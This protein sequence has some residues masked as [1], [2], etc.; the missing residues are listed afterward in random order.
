MTGG[1]ILPV[2]QNAIDHIIDIIV[3]VVK[4]QR[5]PLVAVATLAVGYMIAELVIFNVEL[6]TFENFFRGDLLGVCVLH[7]NE[8]R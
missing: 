4:D 5:E 6:D 3:G 8:L 7:D 2:E 1:A